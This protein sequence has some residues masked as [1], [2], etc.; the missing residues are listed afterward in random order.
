M[1][2]IR[3][4]G[5]TIEQEIEFDWV[6]RERKGELDAHYDDARPIIETLLAFPYEESVEPRWLISNRDK[7]HTFR[8]MTENEVSE[9]VLIENP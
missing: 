6:M 7:D 9:R 4:S 1:A 3:E 2:D 5:L 8:L